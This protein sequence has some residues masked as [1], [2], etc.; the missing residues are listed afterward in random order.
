MK[1]KVKL[2]WVR[3]WNKEL[4]P[5]EWRQLLSEEQYNHLIENEIEGDETRILLGRFIRQALVLTLIVV[6]GILLLK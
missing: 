2:W 1:R 6:V 5:R 4:K 3:L